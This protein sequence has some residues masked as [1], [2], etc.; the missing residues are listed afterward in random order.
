MFQKERFY[1]ITPNGLESE[2][3]FEACILGGDKFKDILEQYTPIRVNRR[4]IA[5]NV[6]IE[7]PKRAEAQEAA[8]LL[9]DMMDGK[10]DVE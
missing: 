8:S 3:T 7:L 4:S 2:N 6:L 5:G 9:Q 10:I 1:K